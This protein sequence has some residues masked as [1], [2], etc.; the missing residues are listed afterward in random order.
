MLSIIGIFT[1]KIDVKMRIIDSM[2]VLSMEI[3]NAINKLNEL[4]QVAKKPIMPFGSPKQ[5]RDENEMRKGLPGRAWFDYP[6][7]WEQPPASALS[8]E[9][10]VRAYLKPDAEKAVKEKFLSLQKLLKQ[11]IIGEA[12]NEMLKD[13]SRTDIQRLELFYTKLKAKNEQAKAEL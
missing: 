4:E 11:D 5:W 12:I 7:G 13:R 6:T 3:Q 9:E 10:A 8:G 1:A 2:S